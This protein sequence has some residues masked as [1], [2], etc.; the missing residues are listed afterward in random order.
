MMSHKSKYPSG[1]GIFSKR[2]KRRLD[3]S[4]LIVICCLL[5]ISTMNPALA[6]QHSYDPN[7]DND[8]GQQ[9]GDCLK[10]INKYCKAWALLLFELENCLQTHIAQLSPAC[11]SH[12]QNTDFRK[13]HR[14][15]LLSP[16]F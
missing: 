13:Y 14:E 6:Q 4:I 12:M 15:E 8:D 1:H 11:R 2:S 5:I 3:I 10:D 7:T 16:D 9:Y